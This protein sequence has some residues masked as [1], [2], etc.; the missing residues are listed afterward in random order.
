MFLVTMFLGYSQGHC[1]KANIT[2]FIAHYL[3]GIMLVRYKTNLA[4]SSEGDVDVPSLALLCSCH[5]NVLF[6]LLTTATYL[7]ASKGQGLYIL[8]V[9]TSVFHLYCA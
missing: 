2:H 3:E 5:V 8:I 1:A 7:N 4:D 9:N 6:L